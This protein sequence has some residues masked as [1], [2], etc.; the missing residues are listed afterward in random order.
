[1]LLQ[2]VLSISWQSQTKSS[3]VVIEYVFTIKSYDEQSNLKLEDFSDPLVALFCQLS[4]RNLPP[5]T[6][7]RES[8][9]QLVLDLLLT[10]AQTLF[11]RQ[12]MS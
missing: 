5:A 10:D 9:D 4:W 6:P 3:F 8:I 7:H 11:V 1:M 12:V 2:Q